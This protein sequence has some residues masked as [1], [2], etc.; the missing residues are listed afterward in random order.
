MPDSDTSKKK[1]SV[2]IAIIVG[3]VLFYM[4]VLYLADKF[5]GSLNLAH[6]LNSKKTMDNHRKELMEKIQRDFHFKNVNAEEYVKE[7]EQII[8]M[9]KKRHLGEWVSFKS[10]TPNIGR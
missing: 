8:T 9:E 4:G 3:V 1:I 7:V 10:F 2:S 6:F 5:T